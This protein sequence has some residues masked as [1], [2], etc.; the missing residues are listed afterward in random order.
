MLITQL[1]ST[2]LYNSTA[3]REREGAEPLQEGQ[4]RRA[5]Q[6]ATP[7]CGVATA[8]ELHE[9][10]A[11]VL[12]ELAVWLQ[13][14]DEWLRWVSALVPGTR[15]QVGRA[16]PAKFYKS[17][18]FDVSKRTSTDLSKTFSR[19]KISLCTCISYQLPFLI[20][21]NLKRLKKLLL[22]RVSKLPLFPN[23]SRGAVH[24]TRGARGGDA[25]YHASA[26][27]ILLP[28]TAA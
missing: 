28:H 20:F 17:L 15:P 1:N 7:T 9:L 19:L 10:L 25:R 22:S 16:K 26:V 6:V 4:V 13:W 21:A 23:F 3:D 8:S 11:D 18:R 27:V 14:P 12:R 2:Q 24:A 5:S